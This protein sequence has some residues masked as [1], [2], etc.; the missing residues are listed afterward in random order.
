MAGL[1]QSVC[2]LHSGSGEACGTL[3]PTVPKGVPP[4]LSEEKWLRD[5]EMDI[6]RKEVGRKDNTESVREKVRKS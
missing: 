1:R 3:A 2:R 5:T 6:S 4:P